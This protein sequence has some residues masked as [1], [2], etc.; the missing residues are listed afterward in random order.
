[1]SMNS[2]MKMM[3]LP[4]NKKNFGLGFMNIHK[5]FQPLNWLIRILKNGNRQLEQ[6]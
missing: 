6:S 4:K 5:S 2:Q 1:M 3:F